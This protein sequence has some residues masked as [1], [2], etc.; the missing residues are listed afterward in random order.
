MKRFFIIIVSIFLFIP[1]F[2]FSATILEDDFNSY[3]DGDLN[4]QGSWSGS[5]NWDIQGVQTYEGIKAIECATG[6]SMISKSGTGIDTGR[7]NFYI[8]VESNAGVGA[9][10]SLKEGN[11]S[12]AEVGIGVA[13]D[14]IH[15]KYLDDQ[16]VWTDFDDFTLNDWNLVEVEWRISDKKTRYRLNEGTWTDWVLPYDIFVSYIDKI[17]IYR[18][19]GE[20]TASVFIDYIAENPYGYVPPQPEITLNDLFYLIQN[21]ETNAEFYLQKSLT[22][23]DLLIVIFLSIFLIFSIFK[24]LWNFVWAEFK[25]KL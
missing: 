5:T 6:A 10:F 17:Q 20:A 25:R 12:I 23:G 15:I 16:A 3:N 1:C 7:I 9:E 24:F 8:F 19:S 13:D 22:Y 14:F 11:N 18:Y 2:C 4:G 21:S